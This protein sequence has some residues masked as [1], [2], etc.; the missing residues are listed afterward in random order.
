MTIPTLQGLQT[1]LSGLMA[2]QQAMD[3]TGNNVA[4]ANTEGY[5]RER[6]VLSPNTPIDIAALSPL[7]GAGGAARHRRR[8]RNL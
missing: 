6:A 7:T 2:E 3:I 4:N 5:S 8:G 1:A